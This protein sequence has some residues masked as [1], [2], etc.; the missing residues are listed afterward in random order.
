MTDPTNF[1]DA[2]ALKIAGIVG[3]LCSLKYIKGTWYER[4]TMVTFAIFASYYGSAPLSE[5]LGIPEGLTGLLIGFLAAA[6]ADKLIETVQ[7]AD[8]WSAIK[9]KVGL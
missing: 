6:L 5:K 9:K 4:L 7:N 2:I 1:I 3:A 8:V